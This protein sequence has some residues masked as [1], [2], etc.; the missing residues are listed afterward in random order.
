MKK[1]VVLL[2]IAAMSCF[3]LA[4]SAADVTIQLASAFEPT[5]ILSQSAQKFKELVEEKS[6]GA[7]TV[8]L[9]LG[10]VMGSEEECTESVSIGAVQMQAGGGLPIKTYAPEYYFLDSPYVI[11]DWEHFQNVFYNS[12]IGKKAQELIATNGNTVYLGV[13][14]RGARQFTSNK[15]IKTPADLQG[16]KLRL[17]QLPTWIA[18]WKAVG[19]LP[20]PVALTELFSALQTGVADASEGDV[21]QIHSFH[22]DEVQKYL[23]M[24][25]HLVQTGALTINKTFL[26]SL[27]AEQQAIIKE[28]GKEAADWGS[29]KI[30][31]GEAELIADLKAKGM[32]VVIPDADAFREKAKPAVEQLFKEQWPVAT[33][34]EVL[35]Y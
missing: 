13:V 26:E 33:W 28:A 30:I 12:P 32:E 11:R 2:A 15:P 23:S 5:H 25:N 29:Q 35:S 17:P 18:V 3:A 10:G 16:I 9:F 8:E 14:Y 22:L 34:E 4:A 19:A 21:S 27:T 7:I 24:T 6:G 31:D 20:V 1:F